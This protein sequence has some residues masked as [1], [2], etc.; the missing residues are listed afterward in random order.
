MNHQP[1]P[2]APPAGLAAA[3]VAL[4]S[5]TDMYAGLPTPY[6]AIHTF[7]GTSTVNF[8][9]DTP[10]GFEQWRTA[11]TV[12][13]EAIDLKAYACDT[14]LAATAVFQGIEIKLAGYGI[15]LAPELVA[16][17]A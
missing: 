14:W 16:V 1:S 10:H 11:L 13:A 9:L 6:V 7:D 4:V 3:A 12:P 17:A 8:Q 15:E 5:L 2:T